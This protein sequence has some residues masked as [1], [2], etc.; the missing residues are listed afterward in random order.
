[1]LTRL[2]GY[3][4]DGLRFD[5]GGKTQRILPNLKPRDA[6]KVLITLKALGADVPDDP[7]IPGKLKGTPS[8]Q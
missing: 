8:L 6:E 5:A 1:V 7:L 3:S 2:R 4:I